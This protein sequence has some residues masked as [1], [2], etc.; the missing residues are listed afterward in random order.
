MQ[1]KYR[2]SFPEQGDLGASMSWCAWTCDARSTI[3]QHLQTS[4]LVYVIILALGSPSPCQKQS[5]ILALLCARRSKKQEEWCNGWC[6]LHP[7]EYSNDFWKMAEDLSLTWLCKAHLV[8]LLLPALELWHTGF[9]SCCELQLHVHHC[10]CESPVSA[11]LVSS[12]VAEVAA[13]NNVTATGSLFVLLGCERAVNMPRFQNQLPVKAFL[14]SPLPSYLLFFPLCVAVRKPTLSSRGKLPL[15]EWLS[16][17]GTRSCSC[18]KGSPAT[19]S[20]SHSQHDAV[21]IEKGGLNVPREPLRAW[22]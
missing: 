14:Y 9:S 16:G 21:L 13:Q 18:I 2:A 15:G 11:L 22:F 10:H 1:F 19:A 8:T 5:A 6:W 7:K 12:H 4:V 17:G 3:F 20:F